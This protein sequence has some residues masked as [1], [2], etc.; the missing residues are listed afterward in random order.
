MVAIAVPVFDPNDSDKVIGVLARTTHL[1][2]L[3]DNYEQTI[4]G[5]TSED[6]ETIDRVVALVQ[7]SDWKLLDH[8]WMTPDRLKNLPEEVFDRLTVDSPENSKVI[9]KLTSSTN[10]NGLGEEKSQSHETYFDPVAKVEVASAGATKQY[11]GEWLAAFSPVGKT[12]WTV[13]VQ[14]RKSA[15]MGPVEA[16]RVGLMEWVLWAFVLFLVLIILAW[17]FVIFGGR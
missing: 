9:E 5:G 13:I 14:E 8:P 16:I 17:T 3:L 12:G 7:S 1:G 11:G 10:Q 6:G 2:E 4:R 15:A